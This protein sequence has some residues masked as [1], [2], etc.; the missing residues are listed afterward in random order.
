MQ[1][2]DC[3]QA[4]KY[5]LQV[6]EVF[7]AQFWFCACTESLFNSGGFT[8]CQDPV[9]W[10]ATVRSQSPS[11]PPKQQ[12]PTDLTMQSDQDMEAVNDDDVDSP[13]ATANG[14]AVQPV[15]AEKKKK[16]GKAAPKQAVPASKG[17]QPASAE[18]EDPEKK[19]KKVIACTMHATTVC[20]HTVYDVCL[21]C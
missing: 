15:S 2:I 21:A 19:A 6:L 3:L 16:P 14:P 18:Q 20:I 4:T 1:C 8:M 11:T 17:E 5:T 7:A 10:K 12:R 13:T 9:G